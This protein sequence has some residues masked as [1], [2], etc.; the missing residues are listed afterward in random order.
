MFDLRS[1]HTQDLG[2]DPRWE[3]LPK[4]AVSGR[5]GTVVDEAVCVLSEEAWSTAPVLLLAT[6]LRTS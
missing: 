5:V 6:G 1:L 3:N 2:E 4:K